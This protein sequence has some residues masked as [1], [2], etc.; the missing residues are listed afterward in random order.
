MAALDNASG[1]Y[2][3]SKRSKQ[4]NQHAKAAMMSAVDHQRKGSEE[5]QRYYKKKRTEGKTHN[6]AIRPLGCH[7]SRAISSLKLSGAWWKVE[8]VRPMLTL[9][10]VRENEEWENY[11]DNSAKAA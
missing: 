6:Q 2:Q 1:K 4:I 8:N 7:L 5:S 11:W 9:R 3:G 10:V